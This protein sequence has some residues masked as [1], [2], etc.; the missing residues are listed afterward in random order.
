MDV[1]LKPELLARYGLPAIGYPISELAWQAALHGDGA[2]PL[3]D[4]LCGLQQ[5]AAAGDADWRS[6]EPALGRLSELLA[7]DDAAE[8]TTVAGDDWWLELGPVDLAREIVTVQRDGELVAAMAPREDGRLRVAV[9]RPQDAGSA[10]MLIR[11]G[12]HPGADGKVCM[13]DNNWEYALDSSAGLGQMLAADAGLAYRSYWQYGLGIN[14]DGERVPG[15]WEQRTLAP[16]RVACV[17]TEL[18]VCFELSDG[19]GTV[20]SARDG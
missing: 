18:G 13:R 8:I 15:W 1:H 7:P 6:L 4:M 2:L 17:A 19:D 12:Q 14:A 11:S 3:A 10:W 20:P 9:Y 5:R 16:R